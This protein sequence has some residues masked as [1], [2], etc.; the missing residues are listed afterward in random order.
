MSFQDS[1]ES[2][3]ELR[4]EMLDQLLKCKDNGCNIE[5]KE[6]LLSQ[7]LKAKEIQSTNNID[8]NKE[9]QEN[10]KNESKKNIKFED[11]TNIDAKEN[12]SEI[13]SKVDKKINKVK[14]SSEVSSSFNINGNEN[15]ENSSSYYKKKFNLDNP[16][17]KIKHLNNLK[18]KQKSSVKMRI[19]PKKQEP[20]TPRELLYIIDNYNR[21][22]KKLKNDYNRYKTKY[23]V[24][25]IDTTG[26]D[27]LIN[28]NKSLSQNLKSKINNPELSYNEII[29]E[30]QK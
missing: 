26:I 13:D 3:D 20:T 15:E 1:F 8:E 11:D 21:L 17:M 27:K 28:N 19:F 9:I 7:L 14:S 12:K 25:S 5:L 23:S 4:N 18:P 6:K 22:N 2:L 30:L 10:N 29:K 16:N 24:Y